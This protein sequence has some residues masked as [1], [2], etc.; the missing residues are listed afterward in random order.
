M[1][2]DSSDKHHNKPRKAKKRKKVRNILIVIILVLVIFRILLP[3]IVLRYVNK[4]L[5]EMDEYY[6]HVEDIDIHL[7]RGAYVIKDIEIVKIQK[8][9]IKHDTIPFVK[10]DDID[11][12]VEWESLFKGRIVGEIYFKKP[13]VNFVKTKSPD[14]SISE[15]TADFKKLLKD[16]MPI[17][18][19]HFEVERGEIHYIDPFSSPSLDIY[20]DSISVVASN[21]SNVSK[22]DKLF[23]ANIKASGTVYNGAFDLNIDMDALAEDP[24]FDMSAELLKL[25]MTNINPML[26]AYANFDV[27]EGNFSVYSEFA[28]K[29]GD[30][31]GY[32]KPIVKD[33]DVVQWTKEEGSIPQIAWE[34]L[35]GVTAEIFQNQNKEQLATKVNIE[36]EF[37]NPDINV[38]RAVGYVLQNAFWQAL[39]PVIE[40]SISVGEIDKKKEDQSLL[41]KIFKPDGDKKKEENTSK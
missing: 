5:A 6:G 14:G 17:T 11:L 7:Y 9:K 30:F 33:L 28:A 25:D 1:S 21:L 29:E 12:S 4:T 36:G 27:K 18:V 10:A 26:Q 41:E 22:K 34:T 23:P 35:I 31:V 39:K 15:D 32:V 20:M 19:N 38:F 40:N 8:Q 37:N 2:T 24:T 13:V 3:T 16:L